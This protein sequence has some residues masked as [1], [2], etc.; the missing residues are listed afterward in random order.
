MRNLKREATRFVPS[1]LRVPRPQPS[2][3]GPKIP[4]IAA[5]GTQIIPKKKKLNRQTGKSVD[6]ACDEFL[7]EI[8]GLL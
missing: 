3:I 6:E 5:P 8:G 2:S 1:T 4:S 7:K